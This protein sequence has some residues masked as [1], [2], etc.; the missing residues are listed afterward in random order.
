MMDDI[1]RKT[2]VLQRTIQLTASLAAAR[3]G[4]EPLALSSTL[5]EGLKELEQQR[6]TQLFGTCALSAHS[7][8][9]T[10]LLLLC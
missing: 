3:V 8:A 2:S 7:T 10:V 6:P 5:R 1:I 4:Y 9:A